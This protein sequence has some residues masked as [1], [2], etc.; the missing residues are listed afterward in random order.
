MSMRVRISTL[1]LLVGLTALVPAAGAAH[2]QIARRDRWSVWAHRAYGPQLR[3]VFGRSPRR[4]ERSAAFGETTG[5]G[6]A[7]VGS[8]PVGNGPSTLALN[9]ATHTLYVANG[10][11]D[12]GPNA[13]GNTVSVIDTRRC[14]VHD[15]SNCTGPWPTITVGSLPSGVAIDQ[16][17]DTVYVTDVADNM[18]SVFN[19]GTC[20]AENT[21]GCGQTPAAVPVGLAPLELFADLANH[22]VYVVNYGAPA[23]GGP[24]GDSTTVSMINSATCNAADLAACPKTAPPTVDVGAAPDDV[25]VDQ[26]THTVYVT[27]IGALNG[28]SVFDAN[29]CN[30]TDQSGCATLGYLTGD[31][32]GPNAAQVD[33]ANDT[34]YTANYDNT[35]SA[36]DLHQCDAADLAGCASDV[37]GTVTVPPG[38]GLG[39]DHVLWLAVDAPLHTV[40][41]VYQKDDVL[42]VIDTNLCSGADPAGCATLN[43]PEIHTG[44]GPEMVRLDPQTQTLYTADEVDNNVSVIDATRC[45]AQTTLGCMHPAPE[46]PI[47]SA[48]LAADAAVATTYV[49]GGT[50]TV[51][52]IDTRDCYTHHPAGC[53]TAPATVTVGTS[54]VAVA[55][56]PATHT[57]YVADFGADT[58]GTVSV[59]DDRTCNASHQ[60]GCG[61]VST[62]QVPGGNPGDIAVNAK[63]DTVY[64]ATITGTGPNLISVF[65]GATC[66]AADTAGCQQTPVTLSVGDSGGCPGC[67]AL[68]LAIDPLT[69]TVYATNVILD[70]APFIG[71]SVYVIDGATCD[72]E[73]GTGCGQTPATVTIAANP[74]IGANPW[75]IAVD[76][77]TDTIYT[78]NIA[79]GE[80]PGTVSMINGATCNGQNTTGCGQTPIT[81][82]AGFGAVGIATDPITDDVYTANTENASVSVIGGDTCNR[83][84]ATGCSHTP[85]EVAVGDYPGSIAVDPAVDTAYVQNI[86]G[87][88][89]VPLNP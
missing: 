2:K 49:A 67:S 66:N 16:G 54:P 52:M 34:L 59:F 35:V 39:F 15:I 76:Q 77:A 19:G 45:D 55:V 62:L 86:E 27:T 69:N 84:N 44:A 32:I 40:Y 14:H 87:V 53:A 1:V 78:A 38:P 10:N 60:A 88:S 29:T 72:A 25:E 31:Q 68:N 37:P 4:M 47:G 85:A 70:T 51:S 36:F 43:P 82:P 13:G 41:A 63:T 28:W 83:L 75:G 24:P 33:T 30:A 89:V 21:R 80:T 7:L 6:S 46:V 50:N 3:D 42:R 11:N 8:A 64:V 74:P 73:N 79:D 17:T 71:N 9:P 81:A 65:D 12:N 57:V 48:G 58:S 26:S 23:F 18:V 5:F 56:N 22:T 61:A 20:N